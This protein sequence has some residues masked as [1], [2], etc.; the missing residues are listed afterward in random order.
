MENFEGQQMLATEYYS[1][2]SLLEVV[3]NEKSWV[4]D[5]QARDYLPVDYTVVDG[6]AVAEGDIVLGTADELARVA[7]IVGNSSVQDVEIPDAYIITTGKT[8]SAKKVYYKI[9][10]TSTSGGVSYKFSKTDLKKID[11]AIATVGEETALKMIERRGEKDYVNIIPSDGNS[12]SVGCT[13]G[14]QNLR[15]YPGR[16]SKGNAIHECNHAFGMWHEQ[17]RSD[18]DKSVTINE[19]NI[20]VGKEGNFKIK[21]AGETVKTYDYLSIMH[22]G[23]RAFSR[24]AQ[25]T[26]TTIDKA[27]Q[28]K[29]GNRSGYTKKDLGGLKKLYP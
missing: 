26:I 4:Y 25:D 5:E 6:M 21:K 16:F 10:K 7:E 1:S 20:R 11:E 18:R 29:I 2:R 22:Y 12:S 8:W 15:L 14:K 24:N 27:F 9:N 13:G 28:D 19:E 17:S 23:K 3:L